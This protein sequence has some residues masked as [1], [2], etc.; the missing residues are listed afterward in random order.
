M[1][2]PTLVSMVVVSLV[3]MAQANANSTVCSSY[4][5]KVEYSSE[6]YTGGPAPHP[7]QVTSREKI[8]IGNVLSQERVT[9][10]GGRT[11]GNWTVD[12]NLVDQQILQE[13]G[14][15]SF[16]SADFVSRLRVFEPRLGQT[17]E[18][19]VIC[20]RSWMYPP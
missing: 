11:T 8:V 3:F 16:G 10:T 12:V 4:N 5:Q 7:G 2:K 17:I 15:G 14:T 18:S 20:K 19:F 1:N 13:S 6:T 9:R